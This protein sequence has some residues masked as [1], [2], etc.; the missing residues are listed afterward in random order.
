MIQAHANAVIA[1]LDADNTAPALVIH[2]GKVP[3]GAVPPYVLVYFD[4]TDPDVTESRDQTGVSQRYVL[5][6]ITHSVGTTASSSRAIA[7]RVRAALLD[8]IP[9]VAG[10]SCW[11][12]R[13]EE[14]QPTIRDETTLAA[15][16]DSVS[17]YRVESVPA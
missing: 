14:G 2:D 11:P 6:A 17:T 7:Q 10:R 16:F 9:A 4:D 15:S 1:L 13:R 12:I 5:R 3:N 8:V